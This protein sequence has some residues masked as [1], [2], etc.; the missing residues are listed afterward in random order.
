[1]IKR[2]ADQNQSCIDVL[3]DPRNDLKWLAQ[4]RESVESIANFGCGN[5]TEPFALLWILDATEIKVIEKEE[6]H[7]VKPKE[8][9]E[10][11]KKSRK[12][13]CLEGCSVRFIPADMTTTVTK[14]FPNHFDLAYCQEVLYDIRDTYIKSGLQEV[15]VQD[16]INEMARVVKLGGWVIAW[17]TQ[18]GTNETDGFVSEPRDISQHFEAAG[19]CRCS[20]EGAPKWS[21]CYRK[22]LAAEIDC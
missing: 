13:Y 7:L 21:Y 18:I 5:S 3:Q 12:S 2:P 20:L 10:R 17:E 22:P 1:M 19:L 9:L 6:E 15:K 16:A 14:L 8:L 11:L 4:L